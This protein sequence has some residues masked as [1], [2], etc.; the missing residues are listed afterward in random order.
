M[1]K[2]VITGV[3]QAEI[4]EVPDPRPWPTGPWSRSRRAHVHRVQ[5]LS[6]GAPQRQTSATRPPASCK[7][8]PSRA[9][10]N[11]ATAWW[12]C[13]ST[14]AASASSAWPATISTASSAPD[15]AAFTGGTEGRA[16]Y[17]QYLLKPD[18]LLLPIPDDVSDETGLAGLLRPGPHLRRLPAHGRGRL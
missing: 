9:R 17:A 8:S 13:P 5:D 16:T 11:R 12:S 1:K 7:R 10:S 2:V 18:W 6:G 15:F 4:V 14:P 3:R